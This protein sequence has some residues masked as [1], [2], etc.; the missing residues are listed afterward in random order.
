M[1]RNKSLFIQIQTLPPSM[2]CTRKVSIDV[3]CKATNEKS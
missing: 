3:V 1:N 2:H